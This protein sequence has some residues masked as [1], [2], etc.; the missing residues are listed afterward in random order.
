MFIHHLY[1][2][3]HYE[4]SQF[5]PSPRRCLP[6]TGWGAHVHVCVI[7]RRRHG[8]WR[9]SRGEG[10]ALGVRGVGPGQG[11]CWVSGWLRGHL[12]APRRRGARW[13]AALAAG[14]ELALGRRWRCL[15]ELD[16]D[17]A[18]GLGGAA[19]A[20]RWR[21]RGFW[22][23]ELAAVV[24]AVRQTGAVE[25]WVGAVHLFFCVALHEQVD[26]HHPGP[27]RPVTKESKQEKM[28]KRWSVTGAGGDLVT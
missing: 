6:L 2:I 7:V 4:E 9:Q 16:G 25:C 26:W 24:A 8:W 28:M 17:V 19:P 3:F 20:L 11:V 5:L 21:P 23:E 10:L 1:C 13:R 18:G 12:V 15:V 22:V 14:L 27:L